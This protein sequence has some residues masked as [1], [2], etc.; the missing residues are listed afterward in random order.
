MSLA[1]FDL[2]K[3]YLNNMRFE[4]AEK[5]IINSDMSIMQIC[6]ECGFNDYPNFVRRFKQHTG[7]YPL[8]YKKFIDY[9]L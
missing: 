1:F 6:K 9:S 8:E 3:K 7:F 5:L 2:I 4:Y